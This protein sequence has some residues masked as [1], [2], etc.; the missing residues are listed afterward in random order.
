MMA[1]EN[2]YLV[3]TDTGGMTPLGKKIGYQ[4]GDVIY[5]INGAGINAQNFQQV[6]KEIGDKIKEGDPLEITVGRKNAAGNMDT[7][8]LKT[9]FEPMPVQVPG[10]LE[11]IPDP[12]PE[13]LVV[14]NAWLIL[15]D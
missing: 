10:K 9:P 4:I 3:I 8:I 7:V 1:G 12:T 13:Q 11:L 5:S 14:R 6:K 15:K 2:N